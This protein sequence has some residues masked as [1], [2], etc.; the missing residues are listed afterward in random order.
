MIKLLL[1]AD[2]LGYSEAVNYGI[3]KTVREGLIRREDFLRYRA[4][5]ERQERQ[6]SAQLQQQEPQQQEGSLPSPWVRSLIRHGKLMGLDRVTV[7]ETVRQIQ[8]FEDGHIHITYAFS[9][10]LGLFRP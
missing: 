8:V 1:R 7:A 2:D 3:E 5:Y 9:D 6:L 4:D 10:D